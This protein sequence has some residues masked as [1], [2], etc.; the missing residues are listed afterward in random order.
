M[1]NVRDSL[2][3]VCVLFSN[4]MRNIIKGV[5]TEDW[6]FYFGEHWNKKLWWKKVMQSCS[7]WIPAACVDLI[8]SYSFSLIRAMLTC[9]VPLS[10]F[11]KVYAV[12]SALDNI[13]PL[14]LSQLYA[15]LWKV[16]ENFHSRQKIGK[17][18]EVDFSVDLWHVS[19]R[20]IPS[21]RRLHT[22]H[23]LLGHLYPF[24]SSR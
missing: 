5:S 12:I 11:G 8:G 14:G 9:C 7:T 19:G 2:I 10:E 16:I 3:C 6:M 22:D 13:L 23:P 18:L 24:E 21:F 15:S 4:L 20:G 17:S 1:L